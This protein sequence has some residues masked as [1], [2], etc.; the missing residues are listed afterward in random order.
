M[1]FGFRGNQVYTNPQLQALVE[2]QRLLGL[3]RDYLTR[4]QARIEDEY[5]KIGYDRVR[6]ETFTFENTSEQRRH[7][8]FS[9]EEGPRIEL[10]V[11]AFDGNAV[12]DAVTLREK[13]FEYAT[14][15]VAR[16]YYVA[17]DVDKTAGL[18]VEW[19]KSQGYLGAKIVNVSR[20]YSLDAKRV[21]VMI[22]IYEGEQT[23]VDRISFRGLSVFT[24]R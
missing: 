12:Y 5:R 16:R 19:V 21:N 9:I 24:P 1:S 18:M 11:I 2:E 23:I 22:Y 8:T 4:L 17:K 13:F 20:T 14:P 3:S 15:A 6:I 10:D 7:V